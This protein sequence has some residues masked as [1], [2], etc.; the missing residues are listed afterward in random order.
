MLRN[1]WFNSI[2]NILFTFIAKL[3]VVLIKTLTARQINDLQ[4]EQI[5]YVWQIFLTIC[6]S[7]SLANVW[8]YLKADSWTYFKLCRVLQYAMWTW[9][10]R[11]KNASIFYIVHQLNMHFVCFTYTPNGGINVVLY[12]YT[13]F[14]RPFSVHLF[15]HPMYKLNDTFVIKSNGTKWKFQSKC[16][17]G[18]YWNFNVLH[19]KYSFQFDLSNIDLVFWLI[20]TDI[21]SATIFVAQK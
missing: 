3:T 8:S 10:R 7:F 14:I 12:A 16:R 21:L 4:K 19:K 17:R 13:F 20:T 18:L 2:S 5:I 15:F 6:Q 1:E 11:H 9:A